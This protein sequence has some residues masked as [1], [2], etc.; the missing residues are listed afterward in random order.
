MQGG[1]YDQHLLLSVMVYANMHYIVGSEHGKQE[2][3]LHHAF[4]LLL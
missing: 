4:W 3:A 1:S 2:I